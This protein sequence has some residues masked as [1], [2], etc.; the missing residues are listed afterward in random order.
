V[1]LGRA[2]DDQVMSTTPAD[3]PLSPGPD[4]YRALL[5]SVS[6][7]VYLVDTARRITVWSRG[8][9]RLTGF[10]EADVLGRRCSDA[11]LNHVDESGRPLCGRR[12]PLSA[13]LRDGQA[14]E[15]HAYMHHRDG[16]L[17]PVHLRASV[18]CDSQGQVLGA[19]ET[20]SDDSLLHATRELAERLRSESETD[21]LTG[22]ANRRALDAELQRRMLRFTGLGEAFTVLFA[23]IDHFKSV[24]DELG[25]D[26]GDEVLRLVGQTIA[27]AGRI[28]DFTGRYGGE[29]FVV[30]A[31]GTSDSATEA[32]ERRRALVSRIRVPGTRR[33]VTISV[34]AASVQAGDSAQSVLQRADA[35]MFSAKEQGRNR[36][37]GET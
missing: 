37:V 2:D 31:P 15:V 34:G 26:C 29:E 18:M 13:T 28:G 1:A 30:V 8:A 32:A 6:D 36:V 22:L 16:H 21:P 20:F 11:I 27:G 9:E 23:D 10:S 12:C 17:A 14:R 19:A 4:F 25:H 3:S 5:D 35:R 7:G 24:N 33:K